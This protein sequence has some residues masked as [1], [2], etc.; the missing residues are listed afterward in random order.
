[1]RTPQRAENAFSPPLSLGKEEGTV[2]LFPLLEMSS[3]DMHFM[4]S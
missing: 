4:F 2:I 1:M 3:L